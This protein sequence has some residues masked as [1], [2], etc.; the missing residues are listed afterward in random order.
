MVEL[1][2]KG[3]ALLVL[4]QEVRVARFGDLSLPAEVAL[5]FREPPPQPFLD[6]AHPVGGQ[7]FALLQHGLGDAHLAEVV[8]EARVA[9]LPQLGTG[10][11]DVL[12]RPLA[13]AVHGQGGAQG[14]LGHAARMARGD[15][16]ALVD[17]DGDGVHHAL[18]EGFDPPVERGVLH[19]HRD[20]AAQ[21]A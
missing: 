16:V 13:G 15:G 3:E 11:G 9:E 18:K 10:E 17:R 21:T 2:E 19:V 8:Q 5:P 14:E 6:H 4:A 7:A 1:G 20:L 12:E